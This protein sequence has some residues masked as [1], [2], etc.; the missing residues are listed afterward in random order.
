MEVPLPYVIGRP[1]KFLALGATIAG[2][3]MT[4]PSAMADVPIAPAQPDPTATSCP[5]V[6]ASPLLSLVGD[7]SQYALVPEGSFENGAPDWSLNNASVVAGNEASNVVSAADSQS[8]SIADGSAVSPPFCLDSTFPSFR[9]FAASS[10]DNKGHML[11][12]SLQWTDA[13][14]DTRTLPLV[15][16]APKSYDSWQLT[17]SLAIGPEL[18]SG[19]TVSAELVFSSK[20]SW[21]VDDVLLDPYAK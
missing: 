15:K 11:A 17:P 8:L 1:T 18:L 9:F 6:S 3:M 10:S 13:Q 4:A 7:Q 21:N 20:G 16:L 12:V 19:M 5:S 14:G 2:L